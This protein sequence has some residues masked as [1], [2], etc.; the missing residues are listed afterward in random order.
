MTDLEERLVTRWSASTVIRAGVVIA[1]VGYL[2]L[3]LYVLFG[4][5]DGNPIGLGLLAFFAVPTGLVILAVGLIKLAVGL[6]LGR[7][8]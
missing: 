8:G 5:P 4:P 7:R 3:Q 6:F 2:P 1:G